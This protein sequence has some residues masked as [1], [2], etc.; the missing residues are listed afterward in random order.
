MANDWVLTHK[1]EA[2]EFVR[3][4]YKTS[5]D[6]R[7]NG[8]PSKHL[9]WDKW[10]RN[11]HS[12]YDPIIKAKKEPWQCTMFMPYSVTNVEIIVSALFKILFGKRQPL[13]FDPRELGD[14]LQAELQSDVLKYEMDKAGFDVEFY[15]VLKESAIFG[16]GFMKFYWEKKYDN[17]R[18]LKPMRRGFAGT[19]K[20][21]LKGEFTS[22]SDVVGY[23][24]EIENALVD[25]R[26]RAECIHIRDIFIE[27]N[28]KDLRAVLHRQKITYNELV[29]MSKQKNSD[30]KPLVDPQSVKDLCMMQEN[31][32]FDD[33][34]RPVQCD[35]GNQDPTLVR[36]DYAKQHSVFEYW[37]PIPRK[38]IDLSMPEDTEEQRAKAE[39]VVEGKILTASGTFY[40]ASEANPN[41]VMEPP[42]LQTD[43]INCG[44]SYGKGICQL[45]EGLQEEGNEIRNL[46]VDN[47]NLTMNKVLV[48]VEGMLRDPR[49]VRSAP[50]AVIRLKGTSV[51]DAKQGVMA[52]EIPPVDIGG[53]R[54]TA[55]IA[56]QIQ[57]TTAAN[58]V[59]IGTASGGRG[60][61]ASTLGGMELLR[62]AAYDRFSVYAYMQGTVLKKAALKIMEFSYQNSDPER[63]HKILGDQPIE[64]LPRVWVPRWKLYKVI[65]PHEMTDMYDVVPADIF[66]MEN[67]GQ[68]A[69]QIASFVQL[70][71][72]T[73]PG[74]N[75]RSA[76]KRL[77]HYNEFTADEI[78]EILSGLP[79]NGPIPTPLTTGQGIPS[80]S[81]P[82]ASPAGEVAPPS[83]P[84]M[85]VP[86]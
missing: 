54:E 70:L 80:I 55:E 13:K 25:N 9:S 76:F 86:A 17:R 23:K 7:N 65:P 2:T 42:F 47:V 71:A 32:R 68:K 40:L 45:I 16:S 62:Q 36:P 26:C 52:L 53:Y 4:F 10:E 57:E 78:D 69:Q 11:Y 49:E 37:G 41:P 75:P 3:R 35:L 27:P 8:S 46:R 5:Y 21:L 77:G 66:T 34:V 83:S 48:V 12:I 14:E 81:K 59:T 20:S 38:W 18:V 74:F 85:G 15:K 82:G 28:S 67:K 44:Q 84:A 24:E 33:D 56:S 61:P 31:D 72:S 64:F 30:G 73:I 79:P 1:R 60:D 39:E 63:I 6:W 58:K 19:A 51:T 29:V 50:G 43:Y 22:P